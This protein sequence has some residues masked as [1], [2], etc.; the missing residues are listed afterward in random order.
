MEDCGNC[1]GVF[2]DSF[3][4]LSEAYA[5]EMDVCIATELKAT[6]AVRIQTET[7]M[8]KMDVLFQSTTQ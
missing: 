6:C 4:T 2:H 5:A 7:S 8:E 1:G 3:P